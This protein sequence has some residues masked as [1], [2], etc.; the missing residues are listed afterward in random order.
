MR[1]DPPGAARSVEAG[2]Q[3]VKVHDEDTGAARPL[4]T[5]PTAPVLRKPMEQ[6]VSV[7][8]LWDAP[9]PGTGSHLIPSGCQ[10]EV[11]G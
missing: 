8:S 9:F 3:R 7:Y 5:D 11:A 2:E 1:P 6:P 4:Q 10:L